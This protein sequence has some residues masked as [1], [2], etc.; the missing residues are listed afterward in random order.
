MKHN[1]SKFDT[2]ISHIIGVTLADVKPYFQELRKYFND[3]IKYTKEIEKIN[4][5]AINYDRLPD[6]PGLKEKNTIINNALLKLDSI[7]VVHLIV[8]RNP[9]ISVN[10]NF[11]CDNNSTKHQILIKKTIRRIY[12]YLNVFCNKTY[13]EKYDGMQFDILLYDVPRVMPRTYN[14]KPSEI[15]SIIGKQY[16]FNCTNGYATIKNKKFYICVTRFAGSLGLLVHELGH[17]CS[18]DLGKFDDGDYNFSDDRLLEWRDIKK[19]FDIDP[20]CKIGN[21]TEGINNGNSSIIHALFI[22]LENNMTKFNDIGVIY[23]RELCYSIDLCGR[24]LHWF[25]YNTI[26]EFIHR[27]KLIYTQD[28]QML[29][30]IL[31]RCVYL[32]C[33]DILGCWHTGIQDDK[34]YINNFYKCLIKCIPIINYVMKNKNIK[35]K[36]V[37][38]EY[39]YYS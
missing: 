13:R 6:I 14:N 2:Y 8:S 24:L 11:Y 37:S 31:F 26:D 22:A 16:Y 32:L 15:N 25:K 20:K 21:A 29:E 10:I 28:S 30:Y 27:D 23:G 39:Y 4:C 7:V 18:M 17:I 19:I 9:N 36:T 3:E 33:F 5:N 1:T 35:T 12:C 38:M 34:I